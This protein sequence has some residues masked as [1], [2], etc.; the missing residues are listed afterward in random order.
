MLLQSISTP[1]IV[2]WYLYLLGVFILLPEVL[3]LD[4]CISVIVAIGAL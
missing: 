3:W 4:I 1:Q 2:F